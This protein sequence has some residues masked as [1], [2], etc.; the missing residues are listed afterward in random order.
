MSVGAIV[1]LKQYISWLFYNKLFL[2][3]FN[4][5]A[6]WFVFCNKN[7]IHLT[8][9]IFVASESRHLM[10]EKLDVV[11]NA[12][13]ILYWRISNVTMCQSSLGN[14]S[15]RKQQR[16]RNLC[17]LFQCSCLP[18]SRFGFLGILVMKSN[19]WIAA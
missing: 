15:N 6:K 18:I 8:S 2:F 9:S 19:E 7:F 5:V 12:Q 4:Q 10:L 17:S 3:I 11:C 16:N 13:S 1:Y 14:G